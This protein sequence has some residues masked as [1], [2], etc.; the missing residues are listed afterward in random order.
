MY[1]FTGLGTNEVL[2]SPETG[3]VR[4]GGSEAI[5]CVLKQTAEGTFS[6]QDTQSRADLISINETEHA[7]KPPVGQP[8]YTNYGSTKVTCTWTPQSDGQPLKKTLTVRILPKDLAGTIDGKTTGDLTLMAG[9]KRTLQCGLLPSDAAEKLNGLWNATADPAEAATIQIPEDHTKAE[10][11]PPTEQ[12]FLEVPGE[13]SVRCV[14]YS[15]E[16]TVI[17]EFTQKVIVNQNVK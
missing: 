9:D 7:I 14:F 1:I 16:N 12:G 4:V 11:L 8:A 5:T 3:I 10:V 2:F 6:L 13:F 17:H 15:P